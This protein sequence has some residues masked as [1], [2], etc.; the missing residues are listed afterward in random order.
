MTA[1]RL[2]TAEPVATEQLCCRCRAPGLTW[3]RIAG[4]PYCPDCEEALVQGDAEPLVE[5]CEPTPC[6]VCAATGTLSYLTFPLQSR[7]PVEIQLCGRHLRDLLARRLAP[8][9][10]HHIRRQLAAFRIDVGRVFLLHDA[11]YDAEGRSLQP[12][13]DPE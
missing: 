7:T 9:A 12:A 5:R 2:L 4:R 6:G 10:Y 11:F 8:T 3:D 13:T 1:L